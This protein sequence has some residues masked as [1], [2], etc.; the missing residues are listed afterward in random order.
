[1]PRKPVDRSSIDISA[2]SI[3]ILD[4]SWKLRIDLAEPRVLLC[5]DV[6]INLNLKKDINQNM[7]F[8]SR[9]AI[10]KDRSLSKVLIGPLFVV[11]DCTSWSRSMKSSSRVLV[12][13]LFTTF[14]RNSRSRSVEGTSRVLVHP[15]SIAV[16][17][18]DP[19]EWKQFRGAVAKIDPLPP[20]PHFSHILR[21]LFIAEVSS[22]PF[23]PLCIV[24]L[25]NTTAPGYG[26]GRFTK[27]F[28]R[29]VFDR[30]LEEEFFEN[31]QHEGP[32]RSNF[33]GSV[34]DQEAVL[35]NRGEE[36]GGSKLSGM[37]NDAILWLESFGYRMAMKV[38]YAEIS[39][40]KAMIVFAI[41]DA[42]SLMSL[43]SHSVGTS[44]KLFHICSTVTMVQEMASLVCLNM[45]GCFFGYA[46]PACECF[47]AV[48]TESVRQTTSV[49]FGFV[50]AVGNSEDLAGKS[51][52]FIEGYA[53]LRGD[54]GGCHNVVSSRSLSRL[55][56]Q[57]SNLSSVAS[58]LGLLSQI[59][60]VE[61]KSY[62]GTDEKVGNGN[63]GTRFYSSEFPFSSWK[64]CSSCATHP[65]S[66]AKRV[67]RTRISERMRKLQ[68][69]VQNMS[70]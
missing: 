19:M 39:K 31:D 5:G 53:L 15:S 59:T 4:H 46:Y 16:P 24:V 14:N 6:M 7:E 42:Q 66:I 56:L 41:D 27:V 21:S 61:N 11:F 45:L 49:D 57:M 64:H 63:S 47:K 12:D 36:V 37:Q 23:N 26:E 13:S 30:V 51:V 22:M 8:N 28:D 65:R 29:E 40:L 18:A 69:L 38:K 10:F 70:I 9:S 60:E 58:S 17:G 43:D 55:K 67:R 1:M 34:V 33:N 50:V 3:E 35:E 20:Q 2:R 48:E 25:V 62:V 44:N 54:L 68:E 32:E 52:D